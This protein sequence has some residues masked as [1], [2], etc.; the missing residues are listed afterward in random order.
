MGVYR[1]VEWAAMA[2]VAG[3]LAGAGEASLPAAPA[4]LILAGVAIA[5]GGWWRRTP[6]I[7]VAGIAVALGGASWG[8]AAATR[9]LPVA[10]CEVA[11]LA[12]PTRARVVGRVASMPTLE[13]G[14]TTFVL[15][16]ETIAYDAAASPVC[17]RLR[18]RVDGPLAGLRRGE[19]LAFEAT[20]RRPRNFENPGRFD[21]VG[22]LAR[23]R[24]YATASVRDPAG[25]ERH[26]TMVSGWLGRIDGWRETVRAAIAD[27]TTPDVAAILAALVIGDQGMIAPS[28]RRA[29]A[30][31]GVVHRSEERRVG[32]ECRL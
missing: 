14:R 24:V 2:V 29:F 21:V 16:V 20:V 12:L 18:V 4:I 27:A 32:K 7:A 13:P 6:S 25:V 10:G 15:R 5:I 19:R 3:G 1:V 17:G 28:V 23:R 31:A 9:D 22:H 11:R 8:S 26:P 30:R